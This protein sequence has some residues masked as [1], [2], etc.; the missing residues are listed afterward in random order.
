MEILEATVADAAEILALQKSAY[1]FEAK[2]YNDYTIPPM[3]RTVADL[4]GDFSRETILKARFGSSV[5][6]THLSDIAV[7]PLVEE[8][9]DKL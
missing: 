6:I 4:V 1:L 7:E 2:L 8:N 3:T 5:P 9:L